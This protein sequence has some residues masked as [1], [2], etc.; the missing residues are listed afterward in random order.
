MRISLRCLWWLVFVLV[1]VLSAEQAFAGTRVIAASGRDRNNRVDKWRKDRVD[2]FCDG[3]KRSD[4]QA[5]CNTPNTKDD[6]LDELRKAAKELKCG[7][8]LVIYYNG[9]GLRGRLCFVREEKTVSAQEILDAL[10][11]LDCCV[12]VRFVIHAC[13]SGSF[14]EELAKDP[15]VMAIYTCCAANERNYKD[16]YP[17]HDPNCT[18]VQ[19]PLGEDWPTGFEE[20]LEGLPPRTP[21]GDALDEASKTARKKTNEIF[22]DRTTPQSWKREPVQ[23]KA[24]VEKVVSSRLVRVHIWEPR[25]LHCQTKYI[26]LPE[27]ATLPEGLEPCN[28]ITSTVVPVPGDRVYLDGAMTTTD[29]PAID[30]RGHVERVRSNSI[31]VHIWEPEYLR[32]KKKTIRLKEGAELPEGLKHCNWITVTAKV[33][34]PDGD[35][36]QDTGVTTVDPPTTEIRGHVRS[37]SKRRK[38]V[39]VHVWE[40]LVWRCKIRKIKFDTL[41]DGLK[42]CRWIKVPVSITD[43]DGTSIPATG[44]VETASPP[45]A[46]LYGH[47]YEVKPKAKPPYVRVKVESPPEMKCRKFKIEADKIPPWVQV[48]EWITVTVDLTNPKDNTATLPTDGTFGQPPRRRFNAHVEWVDPNGQRIKVHIRQPRSMNCKHRLITDGE[49]IGTGLRKCSTI[50]TNVR[51]VGRGT[52]KAEWVRRAGIAEA[53]D[54][55]TPHLE[56]GY[57]VPESGSTLTTFEFFA[58]YVDADND[59]P[60]TMYAYID[61]EDYPMEQLDP[62]DDD[63]TNG[64][65]Y[66]F[67]TRLSEGTHPFYFEAYDGLGVTTMPPDGEVWS[68][69]VADCLAT[70]DDFEGY[71]ASNRIYYRWID[72]WGYEVPEPGHPGNGTGASVGYA[73][74]P[75]AE[76]TI[77]RGGNQSMPYFYQNDANWEKGHYSEAERT[78]DPAQDWTAGGIAA[79]SLWFH[80]DPCNATEQMYVALEDSTGHIAVANHA[81]SNTLLLDTWQEWNISLNEFTGVI[82]QSVKKMYI[83]FGDRDDPQPGGRGIAYF[84]DIRLCPPRC[85]TEH[86]PA[87]D[88]NDDCVV[89]GRDLKIMAYE[90]LNSNGLLADLY[91]DNM[92]DF[93]DGAILGD[94]WREGPTLWPE[95]GPGPVECLPISHPDYAEWVTIGKPYCWCC[96]AQACG[97]SNCDGF[98]G[99]FELSAITPLVGAEYPSPD[100][101]PCFDYDHD[102]TISAYDLATVEH[103]YGTSP[104][105]LMPVL[106]AHARWWFQSGDQGFTVELEPDTASVDPSST[107]V[108]CFTVSVGPNFKAD[109]TVQVNP[110]SVAGGNWSGSAEPQTIGPGE[111]IPVE[112]CI[113]GENVDVGALVGSE[114]PIQVAE[115]EMWMMPAP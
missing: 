53:P 83:G 81:D 108:G 82:L 58:T 12:K 13:H 2:G 22:R 15:H 74:S 72:G 18:Y 3:V 105:C 71:D 5:D 111:G 52:Y 20:D 55:Y 39:T 1:V 75:Y 11:D 85:I 44:G 40:P 60:L 61:E 95:D 76:Q 64:V 115:A 97:D 14:V 94:M 16:I 24:H 84:D 28:W 114:E 49:A 36:G 110:T 73:E 80:G 42:K 89:D 92:V 102:L 87:A 48:C 103:N 100:Y 78:F 47:V 25:S 59:P 88:L 86:K 41:P 7:D 9:H 50:V 8:E 21:V 32:C 93:K 57:V 54:N 79:L 46:E 109:V 66:V 43:P 63:Q 37:V 70:V 101:I 45:Q 29:A 96:L 98:V 62:T 10:K 27:G 67:R 77:V 106:V 104:V 69:T 38:E 4:P 112:I 23:I 99:E 35:Y 6:F 65:D 17:V 107:F 34:D 31:E 113:R 26:W 68:V 91:E 30:I 56:N 90:W 51:S 33:T 19:T